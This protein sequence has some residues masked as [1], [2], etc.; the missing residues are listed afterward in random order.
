MRK[1]LIQLAIVLA[2]TALL[3]FG[4]V[5]GAPVDKAPKQ[6]ENTGKQG[7]GQEPQLVPEPD[8]E[9]LAQVQPEVYRS[10]EGVQ[11]EAGTRISVLLRE[12]DSEFAE[13]FER[14][15]GQACDEINEAL[16]YTGKDKV[17]VSCNAPAKAQDITGQ[18]AI[19]DEELNLYPDVMAVSLVDADSGEVQFDLAREN[20][21]SIMGFDAYPKY[22]DAVAY[23]GT[24]NARAAAEAA[25]HLKEAMA[26][27]GLSGSV[28]IFASDDTSSNLQT[29][30]AAFTE[31]ISKED[32]KYA[33]STVY[34]LSDLEVKRAEIAVAMTAA[35]KDGEEILPEDLEQEDVIAYLLDAQPDAAGVFFADQQA[36]ETVLPVMAEKMIRAKVV[37][38]GGYEEIAHRAQ[39][40]QLAG[41][42]EENPYGMGYATTVAALRVAALIDQN[43]T[44]DTGYRWLPATE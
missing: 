13:H 22:E 42:I 19:L 12:G 4:A 27:A 18:G 10:V 33:V 14:G 16:A 44:V 5:Q 28:M 3:C 26:A 35:N 15:C 1:K 40:Q 31:R 25:D 6:D 36:A 30:E 37:A 43:V 29:R 34:H 20:G 17:K 32:P 39:A 38:F 2:G 23:V 8:R 9:A 11:V 7:G 21:V 41:V 24:D